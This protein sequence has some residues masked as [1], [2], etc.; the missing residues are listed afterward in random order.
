M[1]NHLQKGMI[2]V[3]MML[4]LLLVMLL[5]SSSIDFLS[6]GEHSNKVVYREIRA[7]GAIQQGLKQALLNVE[8]GQ[9]YC[10]QA[11]PCHLQSN[12][13]SILYYMVPWQLDPCGLI[14]GANGV[15]RYW[16]LVVR[17]EAVDV[18]MSMQVMAV[19][20]EFTLLKCEGQIKYIKQ[21]IQSWH[22]DF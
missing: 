6:L 12:A 3:F 21:G 4:F 10:S 20:P 14:R 16:E 9:F 7:R 11:S 15:A 5:L 22:L 13:I 1:I 17:S 8:Q 19:V 18:P 2:L